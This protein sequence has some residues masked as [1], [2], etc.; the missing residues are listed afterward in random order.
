M[1]RAHW[2]AL[3]FLPGIGSGTARKL[4]ARFGDVVSVF[5]ASPEELEQVPRMTAL[6]AEQLLAM[7]IETL[8]AE[9]LSLDDAGIDLLTWDEQRF[10]PHLRALPDA[11][12]VLF[13][14]GSLRSSDRLAVAIVGA[15]AASPAGIEVARVLGREL[16]ARG[17]TI[18][19]GLAPGVDTAAHRGALESAA[20]R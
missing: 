16:A 18:V 5:A 20:G 7:P 14:R 15:R 19:S 6:R 2:F 1:S 10:P 8:E 4:L 13:M 9:L 3:A 17:L 12:L 11:P